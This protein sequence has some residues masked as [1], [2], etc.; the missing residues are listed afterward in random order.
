MEVFFSQLLKERDTLKQGAKT[1]LETQLM[2]N[3]F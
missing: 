1:I 3:L 2:L